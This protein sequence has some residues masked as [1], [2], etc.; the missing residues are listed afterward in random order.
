MSQSNDNDNGRGSEP[1]RIYQEL[2]RRAAAQF[3]EERAAELE[4]FLR[5]TAG[6]IHDVDRADAHPDL[7]PLFQE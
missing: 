5:T 3:G 7:E 2:R 1:E 6:Q 4:S